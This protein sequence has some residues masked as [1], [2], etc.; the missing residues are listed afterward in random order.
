VLSRLFAR[1]QPEAVARAGMQVQ[2]CIFSNL[3]VLVPINLLHLAER[4]IRHQ[5]DSVAALLKFCCNTEFS[6]EK[7]VQNLPVKMIGLMG[8]AVKFLRYRIEKCLKKEWS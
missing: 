4:P 3:S 2:D 7:F 6:A 1:L 8:F 5:T